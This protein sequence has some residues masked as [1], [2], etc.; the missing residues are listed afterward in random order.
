M[1]ENDYN[2]ILN[3]LQRAPSDALRV[4]LAGCKLEL[5]LREMYAKTD[6]SR[7]KEIGEE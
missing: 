4:I 6:K 5:R 1:K 7:K 3:I 2:R